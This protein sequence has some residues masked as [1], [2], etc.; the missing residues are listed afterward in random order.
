MKRTSLTYNIFGNQLLFLQILCYL[1]DPL[2]VYGKGPIAFKLLN[3]VF[4]R[5]RDVLRPKGH[6]ECVK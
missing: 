1:G 3:R 4:K 6:K 5:I 2:H